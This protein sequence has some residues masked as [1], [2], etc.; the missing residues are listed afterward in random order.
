LEV[1]K[2]MD[3]GSLWKGIYGYDKGGRFLFT[4]P[5]RYRGRHKE[6]GFW[7][8]LTGSG[9]EEGGGTLT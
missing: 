3:V 2:R 9:K 8:T 1:E 5:E 4:N 7:T 6:Q